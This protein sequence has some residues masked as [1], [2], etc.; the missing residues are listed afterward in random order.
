MLEHL[1]SVERQTGRTPQMLL[2]APPLPNGCEE[3]WRIFTEL[4][5][6]RGE[7]LNGPQRITYADLQAF[8]IVTG[9]VLQ[10]W[11]RN[12]IRMADAAYLDQWRQRNAR[13]GD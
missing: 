10:P 3:L 8:Q 5:A 6:C 2:D 13:H 4:D 7:T 11:E 1:I 9:T 12:A